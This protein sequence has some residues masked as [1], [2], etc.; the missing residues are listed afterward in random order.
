MNKQWL[1]N[2]RCIMK[3]QSHHLTIW[4]ISLAIAIP[5][6]ITLGI[7]NFM[8]ALFDRMGLHKPV[9]LA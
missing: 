1:L 2:P 7:F 5:L 3:K 4:L 6:F 9:N 8:L